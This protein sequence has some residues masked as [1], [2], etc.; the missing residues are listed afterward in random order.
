MIK[1]RPNAIRIDRRG[2]FE[3]GGDSLALKEVMRYSPRSGRAQ[4]SQ[5]TSLLEA[6]QAELAAEPV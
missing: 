3:A 4:G 2:G 6:L 1:K 5:E